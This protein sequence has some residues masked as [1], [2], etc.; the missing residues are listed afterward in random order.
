MIPELTAEVRT[1]NMRQGWENGPSRRRGGPASRKELGC[2]PKAAE[3]CGRGPA[4]VDEDGE[5]GRGQPGVRVGPVFFPENL[6]GFAYDAHLLFH[7]CTQQLGSAPGRCPGGCLW[8]H[9]VNIIVI[10]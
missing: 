5:A 7:C 8:T 9:R 1:S 3:P 4:T 2:V 6:S 10:S